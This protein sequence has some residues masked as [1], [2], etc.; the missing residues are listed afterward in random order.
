MFLLGCAL[1]DKCKK[2]YVAFTFCNSKAEY[3]RSVVEQAIQQYKNLND[4]TPTIL[5]QYDP[6]TGEIMPE[7]T[8][9]KFSEYQMPASKADAL[10]PL[11]V[12]FSKEALEYEQWKKERKEK[13]ERKE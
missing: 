13:L 4:L 2:Q 6:D 9:F 3:I 7:K 8:E 12:E 1:Y 11:G 5:C 10:A